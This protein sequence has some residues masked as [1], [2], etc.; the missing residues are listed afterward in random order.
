MAN[1]S[2][3]LIN[4]PFLNLISFLKIL[5]SWQ[6]K[7]YHLMRPR[8]KY[9]ITLVSWCATRE[10]LALSIYFLFSIVVG[11][12]DT[13]GPKWT[14]TTNFTKGIDCGKGI[15]ISEWAWHL[16]FLGGKY[17]NM[18]QVFLLLI[19]IFFFQKRLATTIEMKESLEIQI[20]EV[21]SIFLK[22]SVRKIRKW[23]IFL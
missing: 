17:K 20:Q 4:M 15:C 13:I 8:K 21:C 2:Y 14:A 7:L 16:N 9:R 23:N 5:R 18:F 11:R 1:F 19:E 6:Q 22:Y 10:L 12:N 3:D